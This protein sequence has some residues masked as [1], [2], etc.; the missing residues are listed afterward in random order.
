MSVSLPNGALVAI[1]SGYGT[2]KVISTLSNAS[3]AVAGMAAGH[4]FVTGDY[5]EIT[6]G[7]SRLTNKV[8]KTT[9]ASDNVTLLNQDTTS[10]TAYPAGSGVGTARK[11]SG[12]T[13]LAQILSSASS[14]GQQQFQT[15]QFLEGDSQLRIPTFKDA[16]GLTFS[17]ADDPTLAGYILAAAANDDRLQRA[18]RITL[19]S[20]SELLYNAYVSLNKTPSL[21][22][23]NI[24]AVEATLSLLAE[25]V[26]N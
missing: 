24:M 7:W 23:N 1:A 11:I 17:I 13:Q 12:W 25:P 8:V 5:I 15:Y 20:G 22:V 9:V 18:V 14:G 19:P 16:Q 21:T 26:R 4:G 10:T 2:A 3:P 6:S